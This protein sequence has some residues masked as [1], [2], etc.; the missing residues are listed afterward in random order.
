MKAAEVGDT[1]TAEPSPAEAATEVTAAEPTAAY[2]AAAE[3]AA[4]EMTTAAEA[5]TV[6]TTA[7]ATATGEGVSGKR[8]A[9]QRDRRGE[10][11][12]LVQSER[13]HESC[14]SVAG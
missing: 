6:T 9:T 3:A 13:V 7:A 11:G 5:S 8:S 4:T 12:D 2:V 14:L 10:H 1:G